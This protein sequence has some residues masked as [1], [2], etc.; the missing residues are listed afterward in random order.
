[1]HLS[2][3]DGIIFEW[4]GHK[5]QELNELN[6]DSGFVD[7]TF[8][9]LLSVAAEFKIKVGINIKAYPHRSAESICQDLQYIHAKYGKNPSLLK[10]QERPIVFVYDAQKIERIDSA[11]DWISKNCPTFLIATVCDKNDV[12]DALENGFDGISS[13][14]VSENANWATNIS[15]WPFV[16]K[17]A[18]ERNLLFVPAVGP[19]YSD[20]KVNTWTHSNERSRANGGYY[21]KLWKAAIMADPAVV[22]INSFNNW[23]EGTGIEPSLNIDRFHWEASNWVASGTPTSFLEMTKVWSEEFKNYVPPIP[24]PTPDDE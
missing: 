22:I 6:S 10:F 1:M 5:S 20:R 23:Y 2:G 3:I 11:V 17:D 19:G 18:D 13:Y 9:L 4:W 21:E 14:F 24:T 7:E 8:N 16:V 12:Y 15:N